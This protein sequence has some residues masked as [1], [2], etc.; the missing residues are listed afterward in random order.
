MHA[1]EEIPKEYLIL[2]IY[3]FVLICFFWRYT[4]LWRLELDSEHEV[5][6]L[7][8]GVIFCPLY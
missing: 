7:I 5:T 8:D 3:L 2:F 1:F 4:E 6:D